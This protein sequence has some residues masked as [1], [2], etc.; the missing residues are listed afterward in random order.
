MKKLIYIICFGAA[1]AGFADMEAMMVRAKDSLEKAVTHQRTVMI[2]QFHP[3]RNGNEQ[4][5]IDQVVKACDKV[6]RLERS[7]EGKLDNPAQKQEFAAELLTAMENFPSA[8]F[9]YDQLPQDKRG[10]GIVNGALALFSAFS[11]NFGGVDENIVL[12]QGIPS[13]LITNGW[14]FAA[15]T[16][17]GPEFLNYYKAHAAA[18][19][20][21]WVLAKFR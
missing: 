10:L 13:E 1:V 4:I 17:A 6:F 21:D 2:R 16:E 14:A 9:M 5:V 8:I 15:Q 7:F 19:I 18:D 3:E 11:N 12:E 20:R